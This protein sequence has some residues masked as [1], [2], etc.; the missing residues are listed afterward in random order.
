M[1]FNLVIS[2]YKIN[3]FN[4]SVCRRWKNRFVDFFPNNYLT[5]YWKLLKFFHFVYSNLL[6][7]WFLLDFPKK[8]GDFSFSITQIHKLT[9][10]KMCKFN[11]F[12]LRAIFTFSPHFTCISSEE[13]SDNYMRG[14]LGERREEEK[15]RF[16]G[17]GQE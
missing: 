1:I 2:L 17:F 13:A 12:S 11:H 10:F 16:S 4:F 3:S 7:C 15:T 14:N 6:I 5:V 9:Q 8:K